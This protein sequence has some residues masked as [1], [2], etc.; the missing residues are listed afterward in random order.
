MLSTTLFLMSVE[1]G[2]EFIK[3]F[4]NVEAIWYTLDDQIIKSEGFSTYE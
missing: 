2:L 4:D 3:Q 1:D